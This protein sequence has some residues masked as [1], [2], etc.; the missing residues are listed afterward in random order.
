MENLKVDASSPSPTESKFQFEGVHWPA[1]WKILTRNGVQYG[2][3]IMCKKQFWDRFS[4]QEH[5]SRP[6]TSE[7]ILDD[8][9]CSCWTHC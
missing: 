1:G 7:T 8:G 2:E 4:A 3:C 6:H 5:D 9:C